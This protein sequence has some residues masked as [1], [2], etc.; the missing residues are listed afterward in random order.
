MLRATE[1]STTQH[2]VKYTV[3][4]QEDLTCAVT[5]GE[6]LERNIYIEPRIAIGNSLYKTSAISDSAFNR[7]NILSVDIPEGIEIIGKG[8]FHDCDSIITLN[9]PSTIKEFNGAFVRM[10]NTKN[11]SLPPVKKV[12]TAAFVD[13]SSLESIIIPEGTEYICR[14]AFV[15]CISLKNISLPQ[16]LRVLERGVF[17][18]CQALEKITIPAQVTEIG[19]Y[20]FFECKNLRC[21]YCYA[22]T[23]PRITAIINTANVTVFVPETALDNYKKDFNW[24]EYNIQPMKL[25]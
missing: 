24:A 20:A 10:S 9:L 17:Y 15:S 18:N 3:L 25:E 5:G 2:G 23:P 19:D 12:C 13:N 7:S 8:A 16:S 4:S 14:D 21:I 1:I 11:I 6:G 22:M